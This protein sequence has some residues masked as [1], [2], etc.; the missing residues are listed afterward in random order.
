MGV[1]LVAFVVLVAGAVVA[2]GWQDAWRALEVVGPGGLAVLCALAGLHHA[3][4]AWRWH[5]IVQSAGLGTTPGQ[6]ARH[7][8]G[9]FALT[10]T[11]GRVGEMVRLR[12]LSRE[13]GRGVGTVLPIALADRAIELASM[14]LLIALALALGGPGSAAAWWLLAVAA[15][16]VWTVCRP[17]VLE[18]I[19]TLAARVA[20]RR[21]AR[22]FVTLRRLSR[23][24]APFMR[25]RPFV[26]ALVLG[27]VGWALEGV[28]FWL[29]L[30]WL[31][32]GLPLATA[33]AIFLLAVLAGA[34]SGLPGGLG[35]T[36]VTA[37]TLLVLQGVPTETAV[38]ATAVIRIATLWFAVAI[39][40]AVFPRAERHSVRATPA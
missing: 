1:L 24:L 9:G 28:A 20:G 17:R 11:P 19:I 32:A 25:A 16:L 2:T 35:G 18:R 10:A 38:L 30:D 15:V 21:R 33:T 8:F 22:L 29:L 3:L 14:A 40:L 31:G 34:L 4:R 13:T 27:L 39:G 5:M 6:N 23:R 37:V 12:W 36:E 26:P 7:F